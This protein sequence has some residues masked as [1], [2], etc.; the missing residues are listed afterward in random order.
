[1]NWTY[2]CPM[3][4]A[5]LNPDR[6]VVLVGIKQEERILIGFH[7]EPGNYK[8][9]VPPGTEMEEGTRWDML[10]PVCHM[11]LA[12]EDIE[13]LCVL[14]MR[15]EDKRY[16]V[17]FSLVHGEKVTFVVSGSQVAKKYGKHVEEYS[18]MLLSKEFYF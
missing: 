15:A 2:S 18:P 4:E 8:I 9:Y 12:T 11:S 1:M 17:F 14:D 6:T 3:C 10:C 13:N 16:R 7:P 5:M